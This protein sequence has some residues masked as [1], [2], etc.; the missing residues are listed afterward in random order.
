MLANLDAR[1][2]GVDR[3]ELAA[4]LGRSPRLEVK[5]VDGAQSAL[6]IEKDQGNV[7]ARRCR[8]GQHTRQVDAQAKQAGHAQP[9]KIAAL[10]TITESHAPVHVSPS[11]PSTPGHFRK[12][13]L[14]H[15]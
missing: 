5:G 13:A 4:E 2:L 15:Q 12:P 3:L 8:R 1:N 7:F 11:F 9:E 6:E 10:D 14:T